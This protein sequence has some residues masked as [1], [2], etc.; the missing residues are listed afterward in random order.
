[1]MGS[2]ARGAAPGLY[3]LIG[4][5]ARSEIGLQWELPHALGT[6]AAAIAGKWWQSACESC[7]VD[8][9]PTHVQRT[10]NTLELLVS[11]WNDESDRRRPVCGVPSLLQYID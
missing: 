9:A 10:L 7:L 8:R 5:A 3:L 1:M 6:H 2:Q 4:P 11:R